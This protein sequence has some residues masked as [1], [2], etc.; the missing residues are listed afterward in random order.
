[1]VTASDST[2]PDAAA[3][4]L[5]LQRAIACHRDGQLDEALHAYQALISA[6]PRNAL[7]NL[8]LGEL[9]SQTDRRDEAL[10]LL[11]VAL[12]VGRGREAPRLGEQDVDVSHATMVGASYRLRQG[13]VR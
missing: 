3:F 8:H 12:E 1:M 5:A 2:D 4:E 9:F 11:R 7:V 6:Q 13:G 10:P